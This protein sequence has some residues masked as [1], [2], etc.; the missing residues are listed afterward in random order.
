MRGARLI[1]SRSQ[2]RDCRQVSVTR[3][4]NFASASS[5]KPSSR[6]TAAVSE[7]PQASTERNSAGVTSRRSNASCLGS[8][9]S[10]STLAHSRAW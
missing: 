3:S 9:R 2:I 7:G 4:D 8:Q 1:R 10:S 5:R 6:M